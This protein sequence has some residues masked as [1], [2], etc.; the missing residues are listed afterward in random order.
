MRFVSFI[1]LFCFALYAA[2]PIG[3]SYLN[4]QKVSTP[5]SPASGY[6][7]LYFK[8]DGAPFYLTS[9][10]TE[11]RIAGSLS[12]G[13]IDSQTPAANGL[14]VSG[15]QIYAQS[16]SA[17]VPGM[18]N[19]AAQQIAGAKTFVAAP[20]MSA[21]TASEVVVTDS[22]K[23]LSSVPYAFPATGTTFVIRDSS[24]NLVGNDLVSGLTST[25]SS[26]GTVV[27]TVSSTQVQ[28]LTG[29][30]SH[31][32]RLPA[33]TTLVNGWV[34]EFSNGSTGNLVVQNNG[35]SQLALLPSGAYARLVLLDNGSANGSWDLNW[36]MPS[37]S[38]WGTAGATVTGDLIVTGSV[39]AN[40]IFVSSIVATTG[41]TAPYFSSSSANPASAGV[42]RLSNSDLIDWRN[43]TNSGNNTLGMSTDTLTYSGAFSAASVA[44]TNNLTGANVVV[45]N[46]VSGAALSVGS[47]S[48]FAVTGSG[49][50]GSGTW[51]ATA[52]STAKGGTGQNFSSSTGAVIATSGTM[53]VGSIAGNTSVVTAP[54]VQ[55]FTS[56]TAQ[57][58]TRPSSPTPLYIKVTVVGGGGGGGS[59]Q[60]GASNGS[61][62]GTSTFGTAL[63]SAAGGSGG[64]SSGLAGAGGTPATVNSPA[65]A[66]V[67]VTGGDG[68]PGGLSNGS[69]NA[70]AGGNGG[71]SCLG[72]GG[73]GGSV[74]DTGGSS[75]ATNSGGGGG[76][77]WSP[78]SPNLTAGGGGG[79]GACITAII[80]S[81]ASSYLYTIGDGG[82][83]GTGASAGGAGVI[84]VE[85]YYQ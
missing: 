10:G 49:S 19:T 14:V 67:A 62:G 76:G 66:L 9:A 65:V 82:G 58:Y 18:I 61:S 44:A 6:M 40:A 21:L 75:G 71:N 73:A 2:T 64:Q 53:S 85:E 20:V 51:N 77:E 41:I 52:I 37:G 80:S 43:S 63:L 5:S 28:K 27:M 32:F 47:S 1:L 35:S 22:G 33:A 30:L 79:A 36:M 50:V 25:A 7:D 70:A 3:T 54:T 11:T 12:I 38:S 57:T 68:G 39:T 74:P 55:K 72:G 24:G 46:T 17:S 4:M 23:A 56:G 16:A 8:D 48:Q 26:G 34:Y 84:I 69:N 81:P 15:S 31:T 60:S 13:T 42:F 83:A 29:T 59:D 45:T 78:N